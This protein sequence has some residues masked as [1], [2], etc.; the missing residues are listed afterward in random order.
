MKRI[1]SRREELKAEWKEKRLQPFYDAE[2]TLKRI[3][4]HVEA[5]IKAAPS[6]R[7]REELLGSKKAL[8]N[9]MLLVVTGYET[10]FTEKCRELIRKID[11]RLEEF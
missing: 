4:P 1:A 9:L 3:G 11:K 8:T 6:T 10:E 7:V 2:K 5:M